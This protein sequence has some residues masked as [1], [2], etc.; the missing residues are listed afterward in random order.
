VGGGGYYLTSASGFRNQGSSSYAPAGVATKTTWP[1]VL[2]SNAYVAIATN[3]P[4][5]AIRDTN[6]APDLGYHYD[7]LDYV[8]GG[9]EASSLTFSAGIAVGW[10]RTTSGWEHAGYG[11]FID[12]QQT[13]AFQGTAT[14]PCYWVRLN[15]VQEQDL[16][17]GYGPG[18]LDGEDNQYGDNI[19]L[20]PIVQANFL[21]CTMMANDPGQIARDDSGYL[22]FNAK[23][24]EFYSSGL[25][26]DGMSLGLTNCLFDRSVAGNVQGWVGDFD[27]LVNCT[28]HGGGLVLTPNST[29]FPINVVN[30]SFDGTAISA[31]SYGSNTNYAHYDYNAFKNT[32]GRFPVGGAHDVI[33]TSGFNWQS[34][35]FGNY[36]LPTNSPV[37]DKGGTTADQLGLY[38]FTTQASQVPETNSIVDIG[39]HYVATDASGNPLDPNGNGMDTNG[40][41]YWW[42]AA[43]FGQVGLDPNSDPDGEVYTLLYDYTNG[44]DPN[45][46]QFTAGVTNFYVHSQFV[47]VTLNVTAG[48]PYYYAVLVND[49]NQADASWQPYTSSNITV[50]LG[51]TD[52]IYN[53][54]IGLKGLP[55]NA[56]Q[57]WQTSELPL[58]LDTTPPVLTITNPVL[59]GGTVT[60]IQPWLQLQGYANEQ[61]SGLSYDIS[62]A[63]GLFTN[64]P[65]NVTDQYFDTNKFDFTTNWFQCYDVPLTN[66]VNNITLRASDRAGNVAV[67]NFSVTLDYSGATNPVVQL[68]WPVNGMQ[69]CQGSFTLRG[70]VDDSAAA[71]SAVITDTNGDTNVVM[72]E[73]ERTGVLWVE[74]L[75]LAEGTNWLTLMVTNAAGLPSV[76]NIT[77]VKSDMTLAL[78]SID[79]DLWQPTVNVGGVVSDPA[80]TVYVNDIEADVDDYGNWEANNVPVSSSGVASFDM[81]ATPGGGGDPDASTNVEKNAEVVIMSYGEK[82][83]SDNTDQLGM[84]RQTKSRDYSANYGVAGTLPAYQGRTLQYVTNALHMFDSDYNTWSWGDGWSEDDFYWSPTNLDEYY[85]NMVGDDYTNTSFEYDMGYVTCVPDVDLSGAATG[86]GMAIGVYHYYAKGVSYRWA[87]PDGSNG[88]ASVEAQTKMKLFTGGKAGSGRM[89]LIQLQCMGQGYGQPPPDIQGTAPWMASPVTDITSSLQALR[90]NVGSDGNLWVVE[91][92]NAALDLNLTAPGGFQHYGAWVTPTK[93]RLFVQANNSILRPNRVI[94]GAN[95]A[96]GEKINLSPVFSPA[97]PE[98]PQKSPI[99]WALGGTFVNEFQ[100]SLS[101]GSGYYTNDPF[102]LTLETTAAWWVSGGFN[103]SATYTATVGEG[104]TFPN[105][106]YVA[107]A[108]HGLFTMF[109]PSVQFPATYNLTIIPM[110]TN[111]Y[112]QLGD[113]TPDGEGGIGEAN[114]NTQITSKQPFTGAANWTQLINRKISNNAC[115]LKYVGQDTDGRYDL[116]ASPYN[117][118]DS[119]ITTHA[120]ANI[121]P[122][123]IIPFYDSPAVAVCSGG[124]TIK[125]D[126]QTYLQFTPVG[127][128]SIPVTLGIVTWGWGGTQYGTTLSAPST[129]QPHYDDSDEFPYWTQ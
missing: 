24:S 23:N 41:P 116:D 61:L 59:A 60:V 58:T 117:A 126:F 18:G 87:H 50:T 5:Q 101:K 73:V 72:G 45:V 39:Y 32:A 86:G 30:C 110:V 31:S 1:P 26:G 127:S 38:Q 27:Y 6:A 129:I 89:N 63:T 85:S 16:S 19:A 76:T 35:R 128:G 37:I 105:G 91:P 118:T 10:F 111:G 54:S 15:T 106:Q 93:Y 48:E 74:N 82:R 84:N 115:P 57:T 40:L 55:A 9:C 78:T 66:G 51:S 79:G 42:E 56:T 112:L 65:G 97:L 124:V 68:T 104:L 53:V 12:N 100:P 47:P 94:P 92:D 95:Y 120:N 13:V 2:F 14:A 102:L 33:V 75:P 99:Q 34:S 64:Q 11:I 28:F 52:G 83:T 123:G 3:L 98:E 8:F 81:S 69:L 96:I 49:A 88:G 20:S 21:R 29:A 46:V 121:P 71:V 107:I 44:L 80:A 109:R 22:I 43:Y 108:T 4:P 122:Y 36:Y 77:V 113:A 7:P 125:D 17:A 119:P 25:S 90:K 70:W 103:P 114:F 67:T 62:N